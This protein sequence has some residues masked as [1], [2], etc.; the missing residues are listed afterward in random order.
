[1]HFYWRVIEELKCLG[2]TWIIR[3]PGLLRNYLRWIERKGAAIALSDEVRAPKRSP[4]FRY[5]GTVLSEN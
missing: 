4:L 2:E 3:D 5:K 1:M